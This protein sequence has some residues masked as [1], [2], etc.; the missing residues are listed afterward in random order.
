MA[1]K[2]FGIK[3]LNLIGDAGIP[4]IESPNNLNLNAVNVAISTDVSV[5]DTLK[6]GTG[7]TVHAGVVT[8]TTFDGT[9]TT[10][11]T[12]T[13]STYTGSWVLGASGTNHYTFTGNGLTGAVSDPELTLQKGQKYIFKNRTGG[14]PFRIQDTYQDTSGVGFSTGVTNNAGGD[15]TDIIFEVPHDVPDILYYQCTSH[16]NMS[17]PLKFGA[18]METG[19]KAIEGGT[20]LDIQNFKVKGQWVGSPSVGKSIELISGYDSTTKMAAI[21][22]NL[23][24]TNTGSTYGGDLTFHT[25]PL[26]A[27]PTTPIPESMRISSSGYVTKPRNPLVL[28]RRN[29]NLTGHNSETTVVL[30]NYIE[31]SQSASNAS[32]YFDTSTGLLTAPV[33]GMYLINAAARST[34]QSYGQAWLRVDNARKQWTDVVFPSSSNFACSTHMVYL[35]VGQTVGYQPYESGG[36]N[37]QINDD[38]N[39]TYFRCVLLG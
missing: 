7:V 15:G 4:T 2:G 16:A 20:T 35:T 21:G 6:V 14:H 31:T 39:H 26:Y 1:D 19:L 38:N 23:T 12:A 5:G 27:S 13:T 28:A 30:Y 3:E 10:A 18:A 8:A 24:D 33:S 34:N 36:T 11:G 9:V 25:Q 32:T 17:G 29:G 22:Y 37:G